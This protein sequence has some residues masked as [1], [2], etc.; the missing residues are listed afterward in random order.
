[1]ESDAVA[2]AGKPLSIHLSPPCRPR[3]RPSGP[4]RIDRIL[5]ADR[6]GPVAYRACTSTLRCM[7]TESPCPC[8]RAGA[9]YISAH[10]GVAS[11]PHARRCRSGACGR[12]GSDPVFGKPHTARRWLGCALPSHPRLGSLP[13]HQSRAGRPNCEPA[14][15]RPGFDHRCRT[16]RRPVSS[17][18]GSA[19]ASMRRS[20]PFLEGLLAGS[21]LPWREAWACP[22]RS[23]P[24]ARHASKE[25]GRSSHGRRAPRATTARPTVAQPQSTQRDAERAACPRNARFRVHTPPMSGGHPPLRPRN[26]RTPAVKTRPPRSRRNRH[27]M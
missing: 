13:V 4:P 20:T 1:M 27:A 21:D 18:N 23:S 25:G 14:R 22:C 26:P 12:G 11:R 8:A 9:T 6:P 7:C 24:M 10:I 17:A 3:K 15:A 5:T 16:A 19:A 2:A